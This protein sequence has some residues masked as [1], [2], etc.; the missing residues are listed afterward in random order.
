MSY[1][2]YRHCF[3]ENPKNAHCSYSLSKL[4]WKRISINE[5]KNFFSSVF[6]YSARI[7]ILIKLYG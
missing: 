6:A 5:E 4:M 3:N 7:V 1:R 2:L